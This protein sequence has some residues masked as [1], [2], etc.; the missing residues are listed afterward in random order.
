LELADIKAGLAKRPVNPVKKRQRERLFLPVYGVIA[1]VMLVGLYFFVSYEQTAIATIP[2][3]TTE[4]VFV[5]LTPTPLPT[6][7]PTH[8]PA[9]LEAGGAWETGIGDLLAVKCASCH[10]SAAKTGGLD[11]SAYQAA[12]A[13]GNSGPALVP[14]DPDA[15]LLVTVQSTGSHPG[16][17]SLDE[18]DAV[19]EWIKAGA[20]EN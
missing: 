19:I 12:L 13:G 17:L 7:L 9:P 4:Q 16:Q 10:S 2:P 5:P 15:S 20:P 3:V 18:L 8:T 14:G 1:A 6:P 11:L